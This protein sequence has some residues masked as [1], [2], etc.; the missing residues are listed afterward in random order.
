MWLPDAPLMYLLTSAL[1]PL[2]PNFWLK[3]SLLIVNKPCVEVICGRD[4]VCFSLIGMYRDGHE[5]LNQ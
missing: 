5:Y 1:L 3:D 4:L 2:L